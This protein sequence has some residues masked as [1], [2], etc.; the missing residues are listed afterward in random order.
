MFVCVCVRVPRAQPCS[1][2]SVHLA[3]LD[4]GMVVR[5]EAL[6]PQTGDVL[7]RTFGKA[8]TTFIALPTPP[9]VAPEEAPAGAAE[10]AA[11]GGAAKG[12]KAPAGKKGEVAA[13]PS[14]GEVAATLALDLF[15]LRTG[16]KGDASILLQ[17]GS[18]RSVCP[19]PWAAF[20]TADCALSTAVAKGLAS[21]TPSRRHVACAC[22]DMVVYCSCW[23]ARARVWACTCPCERAPCLCC[24]L[25][26][27]GGVLWWAYC[28]MVCAL[29]CC[30]CVCW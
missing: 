22:V 20:F 25:S 18:A 6:H 29:W 10:A 21:L 7:A 8:S 9:A 24:D 17:V 12:G 4:P 15:K 2:A 3:A 11:A 13:P 26:C 5:L 27:A 1:L 30:V 14:A 16:I 19:P 23:E 28:A